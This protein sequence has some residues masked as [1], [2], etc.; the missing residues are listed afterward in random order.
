MTLLTVM[1]NVDGGSAACVPGDVDVARCGIQLARNLR[2]VFTI[3]ER[4]FYWLKAPTNPFQ[5]DT[6][7]T[8]C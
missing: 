6:I 7:K 8:V 1:M 2:Q 5:T 3:T 4:A